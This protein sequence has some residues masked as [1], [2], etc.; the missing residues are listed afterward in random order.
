MSHFRPLNQCT[1]QRDPN[2]D[3]CQEP[4]EARMHRKDH[5]TRDGGLRMRAASM[6]DAVSAKEVTGRGTAPVGHPAASIMEGT[7]PEQ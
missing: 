2:E 3:R 7:G 5:R 1:K 6:S 4:R